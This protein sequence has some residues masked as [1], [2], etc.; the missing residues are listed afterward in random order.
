MK[1]IAFFSPDLSPLQEWL[2]FP[3]EILRALS[4]T[5]QIDRFSE[6][7]GEDSF[8]YH[9]FSWK[10]I[11]EPYDLV[12]YHYTGS[13]SA[14]ML[15]FLLIHPGYVILRTSSISGDLWKMHTQDGSEA[16]FTEEM[17]FNYGKP[18]EMLAQLMWRGLWGDALERKYPSLR[19]IGESSLFVSAFDSWILDAVR[20]EADLSAYSLLVPPVMERKPAKTKELKITSLHTSESPALVE[21]LINAAV[22]I[23]E[24][25]VLEVTVL[26]DETTY[27]QIERQ[28]KERNAEKF[29][30]PLKPENFDTINKTL[31]SSSLFVHAADPAYPGETSPLIARTAGMLPIILMDTVQNLHLPDE[32]FP[33][34]SYTNFLSDFREII[35][36]IQPGGK[37]SGQLA[38]EAGR[39]IKDSVAGDDA[40]SLEAGLARDVAQSV[41]LKPEWRPPVD[42]PAHLKDYRF[43]LERNLR[44]KLD[45]FPDVSVIEETVNFLLK[46]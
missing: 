4:A 5:G 22:E 24:E 43:K 19:I 15:P 26:C 13:D 27:P 10:N 42:T 39:Y 28:V 45:G 31:E 40:G 36:K 41:K 8:P 1:R 21:Q 25:N 14:F 3:Y 35:E 46:K 38:R 9:E 11:K 20:G 7:G 32:T 17:T 6:K 37:R 44:E 29:I 30:K 23:R 16:D 12:V 34:L 33:R 2:Y 18:G